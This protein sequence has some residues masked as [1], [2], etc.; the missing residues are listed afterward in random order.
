MT[1]AELMAALVGLPPNAKALVW[2]IGAGCAV[3]VGEVVQYYDGPN[4]VLQPKVEG[5]AG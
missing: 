3:E 5:E 2:D 1:I 4:F